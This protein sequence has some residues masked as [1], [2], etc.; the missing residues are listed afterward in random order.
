[1][2]DSIIILLSALLIIPVLLLIIKIKRDFYSGI[3][4][5][6]I[7]CSDCPYYKYYKE[8]EKDS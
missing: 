8:H 4:R 5:D 6:N 1:M 3:V 2:N 7:K